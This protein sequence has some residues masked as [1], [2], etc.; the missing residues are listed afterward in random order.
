[1]AQAPPFA[2]LSFE[3]IAQ[4]R[5]HRLLSK[6]IIIVNQYARILTSSDPQWTQQR[7]FTII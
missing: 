3:Q 2:I 5:K 1:M 6:R 4:I 7:Y